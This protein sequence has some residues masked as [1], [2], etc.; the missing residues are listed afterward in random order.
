MFKK[1][2]LLAVLLVLACP[3]IA[4][5]SIAL[6]SHESAG[7]SQNTFSS[8]GIDTTGSSLLVLSLIHI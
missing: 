5:P 7:S 2:L 8:A 6:V 3:V 1:F 4:W